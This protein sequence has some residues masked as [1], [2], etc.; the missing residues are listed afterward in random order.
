[1]TS[2]S[3][4]D[5]W[6]I[7]EKGGGWYWTDRRIAA[8][9][10]LTEG[11]TVVRL[12]PVEDSRLIQTLS[13]AS[14]KIAENPERAAEI[15]ANWTNGD[16]SSDDVVVLVTKAQRDAARNSGKKL[17][18]WISG[19][20]HR[21]AETQCNRICRICDCGPGNEGVCLCGEKVWSDTGQDLIAF[22]LR[23][24][25]VLRTMLDARNLQEGV[26]VTDELIA[27]LEAASE[28]PSPQPRTDE[29]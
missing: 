28:N 11:L 12:G 19:I 15:R 14:A 18:D 29:S 16:D 8:T 25:R 27:R 24:A 5:G 20:L 17:N 22:S 9:A 10:A 6:L 13:T 21:A 23:A 3:L 7:R 26:A 4:P 1:M 2:T